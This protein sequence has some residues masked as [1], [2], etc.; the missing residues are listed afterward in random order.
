M[1]L[2]RPGNIRG[3]LGAGWCQGGCEQF[4]FFPNDGQELENCLDEAQFECRIDVRTLYVTCVW[5]LV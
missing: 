1:E 2:R 4:W 5:R 3:R